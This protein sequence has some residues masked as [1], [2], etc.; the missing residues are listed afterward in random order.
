MIDGVETIV[1]LA[2]PNLCPG[3]FGLLIGF[4][5]AVGREAYAAD[6]S[7]V[8]LADQILAD[9]VGQVHR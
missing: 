4:K 8:E 5:P 2:A 3:D 6:P 1:L 9:H 7:L